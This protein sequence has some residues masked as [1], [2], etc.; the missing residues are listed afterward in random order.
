MWRDSL[1]TTLAYFLY[2]VWFGFLR[3]CFNSGSQYPE[4][5][6]PQAK[7]CKVL[8]ITVQIVTASFAYLILTHIAKC[9]V[10]ALSYGSLVINAGNHD[11]NFGKVRIV[12]LAS[13]S[14]VLL[15][16]MAFAVMVLS[17]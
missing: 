14:L 2:I 9:S 12:T 1:T 11:I 5:P 16:M 17:P 13:F 7:D 8:L 10:N 4:Q 6:V 15:P 3:I